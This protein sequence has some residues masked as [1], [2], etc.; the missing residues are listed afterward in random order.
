MSIF[1]KLDKFRGNEREEKLRKCV[2]SICKAEPDKSIFLIE[3]EA[4]D[5]FPE[6]RWL[7]WLQEK[8]RKCFLEF[9]TLKQHGLIAAAGLQTNDDFRFIRS[10]C[11]VQIGRA[12]V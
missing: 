1:I 12:H 3:Q 11:E 2:Q 8:I 9:N 4:F 7:Y 10:W 6:T 5:H